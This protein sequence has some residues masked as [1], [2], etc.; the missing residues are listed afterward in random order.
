MAGIAWRG[1]QARLAV[2]SL[3]V[4]HGSLFGTWV[5]RIPAVQDDLD[6]GE[7]ELGVALLFITFGAILAMPV[8]GWV[9]AREGSRATARQ[10][11]VV[12]A[13]LLP[14]VA[15]APNL[16]VLGLALLLFGAAAGA[17]DIAMN[18]HGLE[19]ERRYERPILSSFHAGWSF[20]GLA[21]AGIGALAAWAGVDALSHFAVVAV[22]VGVGALLASRELLPGGADRPESPPR[23]ARPP[24]R[25]LLLAVLAFCGLFAEGAA[26][27]WSAVYL[28]GPLDAGAGVAALGFAA[29]STTMV[30]FRL[31]GDRLTTHWGP[32]ALM[33][34]GGIVAGG[35]LAA[36]LLIGHPAVALAGFACMGAG[37]ATVVP[38]AFRAAGSIPGV[39]AGVGIAA[40][41][42]VGYSA[43]VVGPPLI[44]FVAE[45]AGLPLALGIVVVLLGVL[46]ALAAE[47]QPA[48]ALGQPV[49]EP[50]P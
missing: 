44:G 45:L 11:V 41:T 36:A 8:A 25:L 15:L 26:A 48:R 38:V 6:L 42:T 32:V 28:A 31:L 23:L 12:Y 39:P 3:F 13:A 20:G 5:A 40:L 21:G 49:P 46:A 9:V 17:L 2:T 47:A 35:G 37:L 7:G 50:L 1:T 24:R 18:A 16:V 27:D 29:F 33:R 14:V 30:A 43:F 34:R 19:V 10:S 22:V 4:A